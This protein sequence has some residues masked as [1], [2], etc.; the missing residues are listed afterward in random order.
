MNCFFD[1]SSEVASPDV[2]RRRILLFC[3]NRLAL[4]SMHLVGR[5]LVALFTLGLNIGVSGSVSATDWPKDYIVHEGSQ[6]PNGRYA[7][8]VLSKQAA[9]EQDQTEGNTTYLANTET[10]Q[11]LGE[12][13]GTDYFE[14]QNHRDLQVVWAPDSTT[15]VLQYEGRYGFDSVFVLELRGESFHQVDIGEQI[16]K[17][18]SRLFDGYINANFRFGPNH[19][20]KVRALAYTNPKA[21]PDQPSDFARFQG[22]FD[23]TSSKW[24]ESSA[25]KTN[26]FDSLQSAYQDDF[27]KHMIVAA[28]PA[29]APENF[30]GSVF[31][32]EEEK[33]EALDKL[34]NEIYSAVRSVLPSDRFAKVK[35]EQIAWLKTREAAHSA[36]EKSK[37]TETRIKSLQDLLW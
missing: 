18:L 21:L 26:E 22:T 1:N 4:L 23:L 25:H 24:K 11:V 14:G 27:V 15:S 17:T 37:L 6:S 32:S 34:M 3:D 33:A 5:T 29:Q 20:L 36:E 31:S 2:F 19:Q 9:I 10:R 28:D 30:T 7:I 35:Q 13:R 12:I 8:L 16:K